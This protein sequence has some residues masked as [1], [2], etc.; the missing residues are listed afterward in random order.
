MSRDNGGGAAAVMMAFLLGAISGAALALLYAPAPG[1]D[2]RRRLGEKA[3][4][5]KGLA[6]DVAKRGREFANRQ[7]QSL[8]SALERGKEAYERVR[9][10]DEEHA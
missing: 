6:E 1:E 10:G 2:T 5:G 8:T 3:R 9:Q 7:R 4:E